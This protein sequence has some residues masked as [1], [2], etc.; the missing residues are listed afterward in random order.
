MR[1][2]STGFGGS[3]WREL[4]Q[5][6]FEKLGNKADGRFATHKRRF[7]QRQCVEWQDCGH[8]LDHVIAQRSLHPPQRFV[9]SRAPGDEFRQHR[10]VIWWD[11]RAEF[12]AAIHAHTVAGWLA[13][14]RDRA[15]CWAKSGARIFGVD[16]AFDGVTAQYHI[17]LAEPEFFALGHAQLRLHQIHARDH[18]GNSVFD[19]NASVHFQKVKLAF[20]REQKFQR[21]STN[22]P[23]HLTQTHG[24]FAHLLAHSGRN[25]R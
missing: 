20:G 14:G 9:A 5:L 13:V 1:F 18:F 25:R 23:N 16:P 11:D 21:T 2:I 19:L 12:H 24:S 17:I 7:S 10:I 4:L 3:D 6:C 8:A 15:Q 22:V